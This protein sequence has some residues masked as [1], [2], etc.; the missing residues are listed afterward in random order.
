MQHFAA[1]L[2][3]PVDQIGRSPDTYTVCFFAA[4]TVYCNNALL[5][6]MPERNIDDFFYYSQVGFCFLEV[7]I[8]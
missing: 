1:M 6:C 3:Y 2:I 8:S 5:L 7:N 4:N